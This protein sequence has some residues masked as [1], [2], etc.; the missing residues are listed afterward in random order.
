MLAA[1]PTSHAAAP[2]GHPIPFQGTRGYPPCSRCQGPLQWVD[3][4]QRVN[5]PSLV[6]P[7]QNICAKSEPAVQPAFLSPS[8]GA[9]ESEEQHF[10]PH[11]T[12]M[13]SS[14]PQDAHI[15]AKP[16][17]LGGCWVFFP[18]FFPLCSPLWS[19]LSSCGNVD[20][21]TLLSSATCFEPYNLWF[22]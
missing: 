2:S 7:L 11:P 14:C 6:L 10:S 8:L 18:S 15:S 20:E 3:W 16:K 4:G 12:E 1:Q 19:A 13:N 9:E 5:L 17:H 21:V 22:A